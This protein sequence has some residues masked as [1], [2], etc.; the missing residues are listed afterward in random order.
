MYLSQ[1]QNVFVSNRKTY[2]FKILKCIL[3]QTFLLFHREATQFKTEGG[4]CALNFKFAH[5]RSF[6]PHS[7]NIGLQIQLVRFI[8]YMEGGSTKE[9]DLDDERTTSELSDQ[10]NG[11]VRDKSIYMRWVDNSSFLVFVSNWKMYLSQIAKYICLK[12]QTVFSRFEPTA[13]YL[14]WAR[15]SFN[16]VMKPN[17]KIRRLKPGSGG[18]SCFP[19]GYLG[20]CHFDTS[21]VR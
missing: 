10:C 2:L 20:F 18:H 17:P 6:A 15:L 12:L 13:D 21:W 7:I 4:R 8:S 9:T 11:E 1:C 3:K 19:C 5:K 14:Q 16:P